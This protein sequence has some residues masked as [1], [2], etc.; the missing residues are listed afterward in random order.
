MSLPAGLVTAGDVLRVHEIEDFVRLSSLRGAGLVLHAWATIAAAMT[1]HALWPSAVTLVAAVLVIGGRQLGLF[2]LMHDA[3]HW[4]LFPGARANDRVARWLCAWP[5]GS[6]DLTGYRRA[7]HRHHRHT[8]RPDDPELALV[9]P[10]PLTPAGFWR[11]AAADLSG[12]SAA[13][14]VLAWRPWRASAQPGWRQLRGP[15]LAN[16][17]LLLLLAAAGH[18]TLYPLLWLLPLV[19]WY[20]FA[21]RLRR[22]AEHAMVPHDDDPLR[23][24][25][26]TRAGWL[27]RAVLVPYWMNYHLEHH[28]LV[29][30]PCWKLP[31]AHALLLAR[32][33]GARMELAPGYLDVIRRA[34]AR[35]P[36]PP[37]METPA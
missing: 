18:W 33:Y 31:R 29:F 27:A 17:A 28:L 20:P 13:T 14:A 30:V 25:R 4:R 11:G 26:T 24:T 2:V 12:W 35:R 7:H 6:E 37:P 15:A 8:R 34:S 19:T 36:A 1:L 3:A 32:G 16:A 5:I 10:F 21:A 23:N 22:I 9:A